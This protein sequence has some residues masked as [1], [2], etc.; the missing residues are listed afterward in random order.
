MS[1]CESTIGGERRHQNTNVEAG[2]VAMRRSWSTDSF[3]S[4]SGGGRNCVCSPTKHAG[5]FRCR[6]H[7]HSLNQIQSSPSPPL[8]AVH[9]ESEV[10]MDAAEAK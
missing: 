3:L 2:A 8:P 9:R 5:S 4:Q 6:L 10:L 1:T 7:R